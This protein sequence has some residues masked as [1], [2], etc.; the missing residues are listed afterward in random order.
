MR[1][2]YVSQYFPPEMG[3]PAARVH[4][5][6]RYWAESSHDVTVLTGFPNHPTGVVPPEYRSRFR[7]GVC[8]ERVDGIDVVRTWLFPSPNRKGY[9]R[10]LNYLSFCL[11]ACV[12]GAFVR[13]P[14]VIIATSPQLFVG[15][16]GWWLGKIKRACFFLEI[17]DLWPESITAAGMSDDKAIGIRM[18][19]ALAGF[20]YR[21]SDRIAVV[22]PAFKT[23][24][25]ARWRIRPDKILV[26]ENGV[27]IDLF[28][29]DVDGE[30]E[31]RA[32]G[33][34]GKHIVSF[35]GTLGLAQGLDVL[36]DA[37]VR[38]Q[39]GCPDVVFVLIGEG[40]D[41]ERLATLAQQRKLRNVSFWP[42]QP[43][44]RVPALIRASDICLVLLKKR[45]VFRT[46]IPTKMLEFM[47]CGRP[48]ILGVD[49][50][51]RRLIEEAGA[52]VFIDPEDSEALAQAV[53]RLQGDPELRRTLGENG[54]HYIV[55]RLSR[56]RMAEE[57]IA[58]L[59]KGVADWRN[60]RRG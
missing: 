10:L 38:V 39:E 2:L 40:A 43:R 27:D 19:R 33:L 56:K 7:R 4:E 11:S 26:A 49:G 57:Y 3:A 8:R 6:S 5:L 46:V 18:L 44:A 53:I 29:P 48:V 21:A 28:T 54:R 34:G 51:A 20:L 59:E 13:R 35:I 9:E 30:A 25:V 31:K 50:Q 60:R 14:D 45:D 22:T 15:V 52:G 23:D 41:K 32:L 55:N 42:Q 37:S 16:T 1:I 24:I 36:L 58:L 47:A 17:R 12:T